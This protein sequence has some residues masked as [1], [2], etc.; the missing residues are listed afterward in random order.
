[1]RAASALGLPPPVGENLR[2]AVQPGAGPN[3]L[4]VRSAILG[5]VLAMIATVTFGARLDSLVSHLRCTAGKWAKVRYTSGRGRSRLSAVRRRRRGLALLKTIG[6]TKRQL[7]AAVRLAVHHHRCCGRDHCRRTSRRR[8]VR[9]PRGSVRATEQHGG[10][11]D[12]R[13]PV[14]LSSSSLSWR[15][16]SATSWPR[17][18][19]TW[20]GAPIFSLLLRTEWSIP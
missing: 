13:S 3:G 5:A 16:C 1:M 2:L 12:R 11:T 17:F 20:K 19:S 6:F 9:L 15:S 14:C 4:H 10:R 8:A 7:P 18:R